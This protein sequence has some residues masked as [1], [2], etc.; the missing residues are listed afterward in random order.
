MKTPTIAELVPQLLYQYQAD[1]LERHAETMC[2]REQW[3]QAQDLFLQSLLLRKQAVGEREPSIAFTL[4]KLG[5]ALSHCHQFRKANSTF[6]HSE[7]ILESCYYAGHGY[8]AP[9]LEH[10]ADSLLEEG[11]L[12]D[13][14]MIL[15]RALEIYTKTVTKESNATLRTTYKLALLYLKEEKAIEAQLILEKTIKQVDTPLGPCAEFRY[16]LAF[17]FILQAKFP[18]A[19]QL[20]ELA[21]TEFKQRHNFKRVADCLDTCA[22]LPEKSNEERA[23]LKNKAKTFR[24]RSCFYPTNI[25]LET[26]IRS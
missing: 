5:T 11:M 3:Y 13:A 18:E 9:V 20:L 25:F 24:D 23:A 16:Q 6:A 2:E 15:K 26:L 17:A 4:D 12:A 1:S 22:M 7:Q 8:L 21:I 14:E 10:H 19:L